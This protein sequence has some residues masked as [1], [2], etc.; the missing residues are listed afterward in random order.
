MKTSLEVHETF[1]LLSAYVCAASRFAAAIPNISLQAGETIPGSKIASV[2]DLLNSALTLAHNITGQEF[3]PVSFSG[4]YQEAARILVYQICEA[5]SA[6][7][8]NN[9]EK[10]NMEE[11][12]KAT[13]W[14]EV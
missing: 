13:G 2:S 11:M 5:V 14:Y 7:S 8:L 1:S 10:L 12:K 9:N 4:A 3:R 6:V